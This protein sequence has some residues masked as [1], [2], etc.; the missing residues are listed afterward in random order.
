MTLPI[1]VFAPCGV[2]RMMLNESRSET[3]ADL[4]GRIARLHGR[5]NPEATVRTAPTPSGAG[6]AAS[7]RR[8]DSQAGDQG[9]R[10]TGAG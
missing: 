9:Q 8:R 2:T 1:V 7:G 10:G 5:L 3:S 4:S 6:S